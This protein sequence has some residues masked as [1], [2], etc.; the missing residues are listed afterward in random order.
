GGERL[1]SARRRTLLCGLLVAGVAA[2]GCGIPPSPL[3]FNNNMARANARLAASGKAFYKAVAPLQANQPVDPREVRAAYE[4]MQRERKDLQT[5][6]KKMKPPPNSTVAPEM[7]KKYQDFLDGQQTILDKY[8]SKI[9]DIVEDK[10]KK[11]AAPVAKWKEI[12]PLLGAIQEE[13]QKTSKG[14]TTTQGEYAKAHR[15]KL[16]TPGQKR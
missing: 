10:D 1:M 16:E 15:Y 3:R 12:A 9:V 6:W 14:L 2:A 11:Y 13:E 8:A 5:T 7:L 4:K